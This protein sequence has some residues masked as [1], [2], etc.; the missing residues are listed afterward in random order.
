MLGSQ[1]YTFDRVVRMLL[2]FITVALIVYLIYILRDVLLP[3]VVACLLAYILEPLVSANKK[4]MKLKSRGF[5]VFLTLFEVCTL[6]TLFVYLFTPSV[7]EEMNAV[8][9]MLHNFSANRTDDS[10]IPAVI[11]DFIHDNIDLKALASQ[12]TT[13]DLQKVLGGVWS[14]LTGG[15]NVIVAT[16]EWVLAVIYL[17]FIMID[18]DNIMAGFRRMVP[19]KY[20]DIVFRIGGDIKQSMNHYFRGQALI[21]T[22]VAVIYCIGFSIVGLPL[23]ILMGL[24]IGVLFMVPYLQFITIIPVTLLCIVCSASEGTSFWAMWWQCI[25]VYAFVQIVADIF[26]TPKIMGKTMGLNPAIILL[27]LSIWGSL[28]GILGMIIA[29]P[30]TTLIIDYY[31]R[32]VIAA[33]EKGEKVD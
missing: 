23:A 11:Q 30:V 24:M 19:E 16:V 26:L 14:F 6:L 27:S 5:A 9:R 12:I 3:F 32:Y 28:L 20:R 15:I 33:K 10:V 13:D 2:T 4:A 22:I 21:A 29:L 25:A 1:P 8:S 17:V 7:L 31:N 18:Y